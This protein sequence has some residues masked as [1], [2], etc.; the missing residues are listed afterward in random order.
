MF[1]K[2]VKW[3]WWVGSDVCWGTGGVHPPLSRARTPFIDVEHLIPQG[4]LE[5]RQLAAWPPEHPC[6]EDEDRQ[7][8]LLAGPAW[9]ELFQVW[10][11]VQKTPSLMYLN[12][13]LG[14]FPGG[15]VVKN[16]PAYHCRGPG[17][18]PCWGRSH[19]PWGSWAC[20]PQM[21]SPHSRVCARKTGEV[22]AMR[23]PL[24]ATRESPHTVMKIQGSQKSVNKLNK[25]NSVSG[26]LLWIGLNSKRIWGEQPA[27]YL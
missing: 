14:D 3:C 5:K 9:N 12:S 20:V 4:S 15:P 18:D 10:L 19:M 2:A 21:L 16:L 23:N 24:A 1:W 22:T 26:I 8:L 7:H 17:L 13:V 25:I 11:G 27:P 6:V